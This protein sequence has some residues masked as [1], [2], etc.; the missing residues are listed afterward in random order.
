MKYIIFV[1]AIFVVSCQQSNKS[2]HIPISNYRNLQCENNYE[3]RFRLKDNILLKELFDSMFFHCNDMG[4][5]RSYSGDYSI[6]FSIFEPFLPDYYAHNHAVKEIFFKGLECEGHIHDFNK[7]IFFVDSTKEITN[8]HTSIKSFF[9]HKKNCNIYTEALLIEIRINENKRISD[10]TII[11]LECFIGY[12]LFLKEM[13]TSHGQK[14]KEEL[15]KVVPLN[16]R[17]TPIQYG[18]I[19]PP[20]HP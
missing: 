18:S 4:F 12:Y 20:P 3:K 13:I 6:S 16:I 8:L 1:L 17:L 7:C 5:Q 9:L 15:I 19:S 11:I 10:L 14:E 2:E